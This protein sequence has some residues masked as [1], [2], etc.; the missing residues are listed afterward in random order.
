MA[1]YSQD[2]INQIIK[3]F[4]TQTGGNLGYQDVLKAAQNLGIP[5][6]QVQAAAA[7][8]GVISD[9]PPVSKIN[10]SNY[11]NI[12]GMTGINPDEYGRPTQFAQYTTGA[13]GKTTITQYDTAGNL[14][15]QK[16]VGVMPIP[17]STG[18][19]FG[20]VTDIV[21][22]ISKTTGLSPL[23][24]AALAA[25]GYYGAES[26]LF[27]GTEAAGGTGAVTSPV[28]GSTVT[29]TPLGPLGATGALAGAA[30]AAG[31][32]LGTTAGAAAT[33]A[34]GG[35]TLGTTLGNT[36]TNTLGT[37]LLNKVINTAT[38]GT[39]G[40]TGGTGTT[41]GTGGTSTNL[42]NLFGGLVGG[43]GSL[44]QGNL[45]QG[46][47]QDIANRLQGATT[48][49]VTGSQFRPVGITTRFGQSNFQINPV[50]GQIESAGYT[51][52]ALSNQ[53]QTGAQNVYNLGTGYIAQTPEQ[54]AQQWIT[55]QQNLLA[56]SREL[57]LSNIRN[58]NYQ[59]GREGL[60]VAQGGDLAA[61][62]PELAAYY[63]SLANQNAQLAANAQQFGQQQ[64]QFGTGLLGSGLS[65]MGNIEG[66]A[67]QPFT[68][69][70]GLG[71][72]AATAGANAGRLGLTG[73]GMGTDY[74]YKSA[75]Y[76][77]T[78]NVLTGLSTSP[79]VSNIGGQLL[80]GLFSNWTGMGQPATNFT[81]GSANASL[82]DLFAQQQGGNLIY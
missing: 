64:T 65:L 15:D 16:N 55:S 1:D 56:P 22:G 71:Q 21:N 52:S 58:Q 25:G 30:G 4:A 51:P 2:Y 67:Q 45:S 24:L 72:Q 33:G 54:A 47:A 59:R 82:A 8:T 74:L 20:G 63:N 10:V 14:I 27:G 5:E 79:M 3:D 12:P 39:G 70:T 35:T 43:A 36:V 46:A 44:L 49:A 53:L 26:G 6:S 62:N 73:T 50:T 29:G 23:Q 81:P 17:S 75:T 37:G 34:T 78:A 66:M 28:Y 80:G 69:G 77:P 7:Q 13:D 60:S 11:Q 38:G 40:V 31:G 42:S 9:A 18:G 32:L 68:L 48:S 41:G 57:A 61:A 19:V 76:S